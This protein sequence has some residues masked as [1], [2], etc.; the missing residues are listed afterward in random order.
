MRVLSAI[1]V[2]TL[3][4]SA[5]TLA[6]IT[7]TKQDV[8]NHYTI[9]RTHTTEF[10]LLQGTINV[11]TKGGGN[12]WDFS[13]YTAE[14]STSVTVVNPAGTP[15]IADFPLAN[16]AT[17]GETGS[18]GLV[19][20]TYNYLALN[21]SFDM[22]GSVS[23]TD[24]QGFI[25]L[26]K[27]TYSPPDFLQPLPMNYNDTYSTYTQRTSTTQQGPLP[28]SV[29]TGSQATDAVV[30]AYGTL[31]LPGGGSYAALRIRQIN[32]D[33]VNSISG[34]FISSS[35]A[36]IFITKEGASASI[37]DSGAT[38]A[39]EGEVTINGGVGW[40]GS[41]V[42]SVGDGEIQPVE[43]HLQQ[44]YPNPFNPSTTLSYSIPEKSHVRLSVFDLLGREV[45]QLVNRVQGAGTYRI[46]FDASGLP[47]GTYLYRITAGDFTSVK[48][49]TFV[50]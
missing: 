36:F 2:M 38:T 28:P 33:T 30:D 29:S 25:T 23:A 37:T 7:I 10:A 43:F 19:T 8:T 26:T 47:S 5:A 41:G 46:T 35:T 40:T 42:V 21:G 31:I 44:N 4:W 11:G 48:K 34:D 1:L 22:F 45:A 14:G 13:G 49:M 18:Q 3:L 15:Y 9:G 20:T 17:M 12:T 39:E 16:I 50:R 27:T 32:Y 6:Q 24:F